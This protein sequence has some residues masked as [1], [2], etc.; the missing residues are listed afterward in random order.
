[1]ESVNARGALAPNIAGQAPHAPAMPVRRRHRIAKRTI[2]PQWLNILLGT[3]GAVVLLSG[4]EWLARAGAIDVAF[5]SSPVEIW[6]RT[7]QLLQNGVLL[8]ALWS[9]TQLFLT[10]FVIALVLGLACGILIGWFRV[11]RAIVNPWVSILYA[12]PRI[13]FIPLIVVWAGAGFKAQVVIIVLNAMFPILVNAMAGVDAVDRQL[14]R[15][16]QSFGASNFDVL[17][18]VALP[19]ALPVLVAGV[20]NGMMT[21]LLGTVVAEYFVGLTG[22]GGL[23]FNAGLILDSTT[24][25]VGATIFALAAMFLSAVL[26]ALQSRIDRWR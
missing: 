3:I 6:L 19:G 14:F 15:M 25:L 5:T 18:T 4:W 7:V 9:T 12:A 13:A 20:R 23:I 1:M 10:G 17:R 2:V 24:A 11:A 26:T 22:V 8:P 21:A 16:A